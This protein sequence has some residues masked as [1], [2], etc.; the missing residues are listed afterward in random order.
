MAE[1]GSGASGGYVAFIS[2]SHKDAAVGRWLH[3]RLEGY[4]LPKRLA[5]TEGEDGEVPARLTPI[6]RDRDELPA[7]GD[8][9]EKVRR[10]LAMSRNLIVVCSPH[11]AASPWVAKE[12][13]TF[14]EL[15]PDR[16][17]FTAV[18]DG[19]PGQ[20]FSPALLDGGIEPLAAD[21]RKEGDGRRLG[22]L[23]LVAGLAGVGLDALVQ[24]DAQRRVRIVTWVTAAS[25]T[26]VLAMAFLTAYALDSRAEADRQ[27]AE[28]ESLVEFMLTDLRNSLEDVGRLDVM[29]AVNTRAMR[30]YGAPE[31]LVALSDESLARRARILHAIGDDGLRRHDYPA[32]LQAFQE[33]DDTTGEIVKREPENLDRLVEHTKSLFGLGRVYEA[34][35]DWRRAQIYYSD[36]ASATNRLV[37]ASSSDPD[38]LAKAASAAIAIGNVHFKGPA[39]YASAQ[40]AYEKAIRFLQR[41]E[42]ARP[43]DPFILISSANAHAWLADTFYYRELWAQSLAARARQHAI[44]EGLYRTNPGHA[45]YGFR[46]AAAE[47][48]LAFSLLKTGKRAEGERHLLAAFDL[49]DRLAQRDPDNAEWTALRDKLAGDLAKEGIDHSIRTRGNH[50]QL[51]RGAGALAADATTSTND[52]VKEDGHGFQERPES[53]RAGLYR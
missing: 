31:D 13:T 5:G 24:R 9:S 35:G 42:K 4:R 16:P 43:R 3:R 51:K 49:A 10:A 33:A 1:A 25:L 37:A 26:A 44:A 2:Y 47:R 27:R 41:A 12:I 30:H 28:A 48:G 21:L 22:L 34:Q 52:I 46:F 39:D 38:H 53:R 32:A 40:M 11:S 50:S 6:F 29:A 45:E 36:A 20:C 18:V 14:R 17:I 15:H 23:K 19:V 7:A 8:L